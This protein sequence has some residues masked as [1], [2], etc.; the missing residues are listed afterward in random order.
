MSARSSA[1][2]ASTSSIKRRDTRDELRGRR[3]DGGRGRAAEVCRESLS[4]AQWRAQQQPAPIRL[5][6]PPGRLVEIDFLEHDGARDVKTELTALKAHFASAAA[7]EC[8][9]ERLDAR[10][11]H[12][13]EPLVSPFVAVRS[14]A[15]AARRLLGRLRQGWQFWPVPARRM[16]RP[17][18]HRKPF[19]CSLKKMAALIHRLPGSR[20]DGCYLS[21]AHSS[22]ALGMGS[23]W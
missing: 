14:K 3:R 22:E 12:L 4:F 15:Q 9:L 20:R 2:I 8:R 13:V 1:A 21:D 5:G 19:A 6:Q 17:R 23:G 7:V 10:R 18:Q 11:F 16:A